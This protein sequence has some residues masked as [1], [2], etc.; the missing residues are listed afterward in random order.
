MRRESE[1]IR[2]SSSLSHEQSE[3]EDALL[4]TESDSS[5]AEPQAR[6]RRALTVLSAAEEA[7]EEEQPSRRHLQWPDLEK[8][9]A[10]KGLFG[11]SRVLRA[12]PDDIICREHGNGK[13]CPLC[14]SYANSKDFVKDMFMSA[15]Y[16]IIVG[17]LCSVLVLPMRELP[18]LWSGKGYPETVDA[19]NLLNGRWQ[20]IMIIGTFGLAVGLLKLIV[21]FPERHEGFFKQ[22][23]DQYVHPGDTAKVLIVSAVSVAGGA[24]LGPSQVLGAFGGLLGQ[25]LAEYRGDSDLRTRRSTLHGMGAALGCLFPTPVT[26][27]ILTTELAP[28]EQFQAFYMKYFSEMGTAVLASYMTYLALSKRP[29]LPFLPVYDSLGFYDFDGMH[30]IWAIFLGIISGLIGM[31]MTIIIGTFM[32]IFRAIRKA[33]PENVFTVVSPCIGGIMI[34]ALSFAIPLSFGSGNSQL[35]EV[36][37]HTVKKRI[38]AT[39]LLISVAGKMMSVGISVASGFVGGILFPLYFIGFGVGLAAYLIVD[40]QEKFPLI[41]SLSCFVCAV[42]ASLF[43]IPLTHLVTV[44]AMLQV[45]YSDSAPMFVACVISNI[46]CSGSGMLSRLVQWAREDNLIDAPAIPKTK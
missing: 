20:W 45:G 7:V 23:N 44:M 36:I 10:H 41:L 43:P 1:T 6:L 40:D 4:A 24:S 26:P 8:L 13:R 37:D 27:L 46:V 33:L 19:I 34:G 11:G 18:R 21:H 32:S 22:L 25:T 12:R 35:L 30:I 42:P 29:Y 15:V 2:G 31:S 3:I 16:G 28:V 39:F 38:T 5:E 17:I 9:K 14:T